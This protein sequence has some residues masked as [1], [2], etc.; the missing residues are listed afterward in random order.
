M[1][2]VLWEFKRSPRETFRVSLGESQGRAFVDLRIWQLD[3]TT[4]KSEASTF[5][6][7][8]W[9]EQLADVIAALSVATQH[10]ALSVNPNGTR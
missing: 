6:V 3:N 5:G 9:A 1:N 10:I 8:V 4:G 2:H 7:N